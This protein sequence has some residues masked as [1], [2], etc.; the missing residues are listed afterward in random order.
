MEPDRTGYLRPQP[1]AGSQPLYRMHPNG[2]A[3]LPGDSVRQRKNS[4]LATGDWTLDGIIGYAASSQPPGYP[5]R[6]RTHLFDITTGNNALGTTPA[7]ACGRDY[8]CL[9]RPGYDPPTGLETPNGT[10]SF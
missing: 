4:L 5:Y 10:A 9:A 7:A 6:H 1:F 8:L 2:R 3:R